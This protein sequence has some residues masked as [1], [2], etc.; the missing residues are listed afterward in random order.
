MSFVSIR[1]LKSL[2][3]AALLCKEQGQLLLI[4]CLGCLSCLF[5]SCSKEET[6]AGEWDNWPQRNDIFFASLADSL[7]ANPNQ[8]QRILSYSQSAAT[9]HDIDKYI[10]VKKLE[11][12]T[13]TDS[14]AF[15]DS[16]RIIYQ[17]RLIP[18]ATF[19]EGYIF[20]STVSGQ[21]SSVTSSTTRL[22]VS[23]TVEG[24][25]TALQYMHRGDRWRIFIPS[26]LGYG[27]N[28]N[29]SGTIP[30]HSVLIFDLQLIDFSHAD[31]PM[32]AWS[33]RRN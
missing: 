10:Y 5:I 14:P 22:L 12:G 28:D 32:P 17:G 4:G 1:Q 15:T 30:G 33:S 27:D 2:S 18:S 26:S 9:Y 8:W 13:G 24:F 6:E 20:D 25:S 29:S 21:F 23:N 11:E 7:D 3:Y 19:T 31:Q 16:V